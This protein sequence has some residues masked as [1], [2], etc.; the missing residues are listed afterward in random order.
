MLY[1]RIKTFLYRSAYIRDVLTLMTGTAIAQVIPLILAPIISRVYTSSDMA[2]FAT[3]MSIISILGSVITFKYELAII[4]PEKDEDSFGLTVLSIF[5]ALIISLLVLFG[6]LIFGGDFLKIINNKDVEFGKWIFFIPLSIFTIGLFSSLNFWLTRKTKYKILSISRISQS[7]IML[8]S[9]LG[10]GLTVFKY[11]GLIIGEIGGRLFAAVI[12]AYKTFKDDYKLIKSIKLKTIFKQ[13][14]RYK[15]FPKY[16]LPADIVNVTTNQIPI[17]V[18]GRFFTSQIL[19]NYF[20]MDRILSA[21]I[22]LISR[23]ILDVFKQRASSDYINEGNCRG[24]FVKTFKTL[25]FASIIPTIV[26]FIFSPMLFK[27]IFGSEWE[28]AGEFARIMAL[29]FFFRFTSSPLSYM[30]YIAEKQHYDMIWQVV[31]FF[32]T[33][34]SFFI[35]I[36]FNNIKVCLWCYAISYSIMYIIYLLMSYKLSKGNLIK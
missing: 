26:I 19:G 22:S 33:L 4:L 23:A 12:L 17:F 13:L 31:L 15:N 8:G 28:L 29:L 7:S 25:A 30:F 5:I 2:I 14:K 3:Y 34:A 21:P 32:T 9:Q 16:S 24:V 6:L 10:L 35:G 36:Y 18:F 1:N 20:F 11:F 27:F